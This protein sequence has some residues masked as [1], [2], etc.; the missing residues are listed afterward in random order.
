MTRSYYQRNEG[1]FTKYIDAHPTVT[2]PKRKGGNKQNH[3][4]LLSKINA[5]MIDGCNDKIT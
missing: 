5:H 3:N 4:L 2:N 1:E